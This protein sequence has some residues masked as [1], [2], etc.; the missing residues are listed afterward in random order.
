MDT[1]IMNSENLK[2]SDLQ[3]ITQSYREKKLKEK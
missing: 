2:T 1:I 3:F